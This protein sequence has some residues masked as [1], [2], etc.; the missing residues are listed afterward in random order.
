MTEKE[1]TCGVFLKRENLNASTIV[2][3]RIMIQQTYFS[4][5]NEFLSQEDE[6]LLEKQNFWSFFWKSRNFSALP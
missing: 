3:K 4:A 5:N 6:I 1:E 2:D